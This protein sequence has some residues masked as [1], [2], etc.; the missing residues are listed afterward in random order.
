MASYNLVLKVERENFFFSP[1][2]I[3]AHKKNFQIIARKEDKIGKG[4]R[5][6]NVIINVSYIFIHVKIAAP[7][8]VVL[9][10][11]KESHGKYQEWGKNVLSIGLLA[12]IFTKPFPDI[13]GTADHVEGHY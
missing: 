12:I 6:N 2:R 1:H 3:G 7:L 11:I 13:P 4:Y 9:K 10:E 5:S 8:G